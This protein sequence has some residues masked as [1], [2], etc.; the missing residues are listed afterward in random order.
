MMVSIYQAGKD[1]VALPTNLFIGIVPGLEI[2]I[3]ANILNDTIPLEDSS[4]SNHHTG[5]GIG[6]RSGD[7]IFAS[8]ERCS[9]SSPPAQG[10]LASYYM[11]NV[12]RTKLVF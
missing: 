2:A 12:I 10:I 6:A 9:H 5:T 1:Q 7:H 11:P 4:V 3:R 8:N